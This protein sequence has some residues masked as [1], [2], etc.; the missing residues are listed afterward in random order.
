MFRTGKVPASP[1]E[2]LELYAFMEAAAQSAKN[3][4]EEISLKDV[5]RAARAEIAAKR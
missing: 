3:V 2:T 4:G 5:I 1:D